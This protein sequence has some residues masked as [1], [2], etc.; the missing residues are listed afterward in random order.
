MMVWTREG[1]TPRIRRKKEPGDGTTWEKKKKKTEAEMVDCVNRD[2]RAIGTTLDEV[3]DR[4]G[5]RRIVSAAAT[6]QLSGSV[7]KKKNN[8]LRSIDLFVS[9]VY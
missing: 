2:M 5:W 4:I 7:Q 3:H 6:P 8:C 9:R 1:T